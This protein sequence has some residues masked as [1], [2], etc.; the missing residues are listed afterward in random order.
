MALSQADHL[1]LSEAGAA[2]LAVRAAPQL[3]AGARSSALMWALLACAMFLSAVGCV[4]YGPRV[5][6]IATTCL[7]AAGLTEVA[8]AWVA[9]RPWPSGIAH[10][11]AVGLI[12]GLM[13]PATAPWYV[14]AAGAC[15][16]VGVGK[17][18]M[19]GLGH[20]PW[21][22]TVLA[23][24]GIYALWP[25]YV[26]PQRWP[27][28]AK[29]HVI[30]G[31][32]LQLGPLAV[33]HVP[34]DWGTTVPP[35]GAIGF[36]VVRADAILNQAAE[37]AAPG[38]AVP[39]DAVVRDLLPSW[40][41]ILTGAVAGPIGQGSVLALV[42]VWL[43]LI[44]RGYLRWPLPIAVLGGAFIAAA[45]LPV[46]P[47]G[48]W[49]IGYSADGMPLGLV[50]VG[51]QVLLGPTL[52]TAILLAGETVTSPITNRGQVLYGLGVGILTVTL[53]WWPVALLS[54]C[55][56]VLAMNTLVPPIE[57]LVRRWRL[58]AGR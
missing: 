45:V 11:L 52:F 42:L 10:S 28:L 6:I 35:G 53:R 57:R 5:L 15:L 1:D 2:A 31:N 38:Q 8:C 54:G 22:P 9:Q 47:C 25:E 48:W 32:G 36:A 7:A 21:N 40:W 34:I 33:S 12:A 3:R 43:A 13:L 16:A 17:W 30:V 58:V 49:P 24:L 44:W 29:Q 18:A 27:L 50:W 41:D 14:A 46:S 23:V 26:A 56:A 4:F 19:G 20:Y 39:L 55:W 37:P 51:Y